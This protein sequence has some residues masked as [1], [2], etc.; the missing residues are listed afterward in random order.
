MAHTA[1]RAALLLWMSSAP[2]FAWTEPGGLMVTN[3]SGQ[4]AEVY[5]DGVW[6]GF[7]MDDTSRGFSAVP[8]T[9]DVHVTWSDGTAVVDA[10][11]QLAGGRASPLYVSAPPTGVQLSNHG[12]APLWVEVPGVRPLWLLPGGTAELSVAANAPFTVLGSVYGPGGLVQVSHTTL[13]PCPGHAVRAELG[14]T[15]APPATTVTV[16]NAEDHVLRFYLN[17]AEVAVIPVGETRTWD[18]APGRF[19]VMIVEHVDGVLFSR[20]VTFD[21]RNDHRI[22]VQRG[23]TLVETSHTVAVR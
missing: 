15:A 6:R 13:A 8:G 17:G 12:A 14:Y 7:V 18:V 21:P 3:D 22:R 9:H 19:D 20:S 16:T 4:R 5:V 11:V 10:R 2:A 23:N 1:T